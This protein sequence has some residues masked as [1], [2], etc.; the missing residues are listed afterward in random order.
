MKRDGISQSI[1]VSGES[2]AGKTETTKHL[3]NFLC[4]NNPMADMVKTSVLNANVILEA[5]GNA[6]TKFNKNSSRFMKYIKVSFF[7]SKYYYFESS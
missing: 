6:C 2:G 3:I 1:F 7:E 4:N 5:F